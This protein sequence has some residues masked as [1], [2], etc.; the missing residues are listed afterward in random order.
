MKQ[1]RKNC[2][3]CTKAKVVE[4]EGDFSIKFSL[5]DRQDEQE[6]IPFHKL[7]KMMFDSIKEKEPIFAEYLES[8]SKR[9]KIA[10]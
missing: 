4:G 2:K 10:K 1:I 3:Y 6:I 5:Q 8:L 9:T 7:K